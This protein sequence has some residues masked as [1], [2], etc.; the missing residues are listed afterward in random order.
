MELRRRTIL[1]TLAFLGLTSALAPVLSG[2][3]GEPDSALA[4]MPEVEGDEPFAADTVRRIAKDL[5]KTRHRPSSSLPEAWQA[6][7]YYQHH[8]IQP[9]AD[10]AV[11]AGRSDVQAR[12]HLLAPGSVYRT[13][14]DVYLVENGRQKRLVFEADA[15]RFGPEVPDLPIDERVN[16]S[17]IEL[18]SPG[19]ESNTSNPFLTFQGASY[20]RAMAEGQRYGLSA[21]GLALGTATPGGEEFPEFRTFWLETPEDSA[22]KMVVHALLESP[23]ATGAYRFEIWPGNPTRMDVEVSLF[24]RFKLDHAGLAPLTSMF[25]YDGKNRVNFDD[26]RPAVHNSDGLMVHNGNGEWLWR[27]LNNPGSLQVSQFLD[28]NPRGFGLAQRTRRFSDFGDA[29][30]RFE[31]R[32][33]LWVEPHDPWGKG[34]VS[35]VEIPSKKETNDN[36]VAFWK[37][38]KSLAKGEEHQFGYTLYWC[39]TPP[40]STL[41]SQVAVTRGGRGQ[42]HGRVMAIDFQ[43]TDLLP[44]DTAA[45][46]PYV[47]GYPGIIGDVSVTKNPE[48]G[49]MQVIFEF[50]PGEEGAMELRAQLRTPDGK[51]PLTE[52]WLYRWTS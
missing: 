26:A 16:Y 24:P 8:A 45:V 25:L 37:P 7:S 49:G 23:S 13:P 20:F 18:L 47:S 36:I 48:T 15:F 52:V 1:Q 51:N 6:L 31:I 30:S 2:V 14:V 4:G 28:N 46:R 22:R 43:N 12:G 3:S 17:G 40:V 21:R 5:S 33:T 41:L 27:P 38:E 34:A 29:A 42:K 9:R 50:D 11:W 32:P 44:D 39:W 19:Q 10:K 35:L